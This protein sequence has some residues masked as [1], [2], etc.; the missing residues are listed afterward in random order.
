M[1]PGCSRTPVTVLFCGNWH[2][3]H[4]LILQAYNSFF[5]A[6]GSVPHKE[7]KRWVISLWVPMSI[8]ILL[9]WSLVQL[10]DAPSSRFLPFLG[11]MGNP[12]LVWFR[13]CATNGACLGKYRQQIQVH[14]SLWGANKHAHFLVNQVP[15]ICP[16]KSNWS[17]V[18]MSPCL[19][20]VN[21]GTIVHPVLNCA[22]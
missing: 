4:G 20:R 18:M 19:L 8:S 14:P 2:G 22:L 6:W 10:E 3:D 21:K 16:T 13:V 15:V 9:G 7:T 17:A 5:V 11:S 1:Y 12:S